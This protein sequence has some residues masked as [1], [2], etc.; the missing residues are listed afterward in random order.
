MNFPHF[1]LTQSAESAKSADY[2]PRDPSLRS[3]RQFLSSVESVDRTRG[4]GCEQSVRSVDGARPPITPIKEDS[5]RCSR[6][7]QTNLCES[8]ESVDRSPGLRSVQTV[9]SVEETR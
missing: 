9:R 3:G 1:A 5:F 6:E 2:S 4:P 7:V 8:V